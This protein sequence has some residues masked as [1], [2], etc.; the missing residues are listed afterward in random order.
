MK[1]VFSSRLNSRKGG[2]VPGAKSFSSS[3]FLGQRKEGGKAGV[4]KCPPPP[5]FL[6]SQTHV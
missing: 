3:G 2:L 1:S 4:R 6:V 5:N